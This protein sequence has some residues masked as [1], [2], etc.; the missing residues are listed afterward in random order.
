[1]NKKL[2]S[3]VEAQKNRGSQIHG[4][5]MFSSKGKVIKMDFSYGNWHIY[6]PNTF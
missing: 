5:G 3:K 6:I 1:M 2:V 4:L